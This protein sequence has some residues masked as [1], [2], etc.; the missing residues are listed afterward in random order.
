MFFIEEDH[1]HL[2]ACAAGVGRGLRSPGPGT[3]S[4][5]PRDDPDRFTQKEPS[6]PEANKKLMFKTK[7][8]QKKKKKKLMSILHFPFLIMLKSAGLTRR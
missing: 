1:L 8:I 7:I 2:S 6:P 4:A 5:A 3:T